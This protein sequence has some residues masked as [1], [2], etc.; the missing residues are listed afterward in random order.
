[1]AAEIVGEYSGSL[2][3]GFP[4]NKIAIPSVSIRQSWTVSEGY[5]SVDD[6]PGEDADL[7]GKILSDYR[8]VIQFSGFLITGTGIDNPK[9]GDIVT[10]VGFN[11]AIIQDCNIAYTNKLATVSGTIEAWGVTASAGG[12][13]EG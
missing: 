8:S 3:V 9:K 11:Y 1:M 13:D 12:G 7:A 10:V 4:P 6:I 5:Q 2:H